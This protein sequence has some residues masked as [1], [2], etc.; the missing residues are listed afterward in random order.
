M[1]RKFS[2]KFFGQTKTKI[3]SNWHNTLKNWHS[4]FKFFFWFQYCLAGLFFT[5]FQKTCFNVNFYFQIRTAQYRRK[6]AGQLKLV[7]F[8]DVFFCM[9][10][11]VTEE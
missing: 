5:A 1:L 3:K 9:V 8:I 11:F 7:S 10:H 6:I 4:C 2:I